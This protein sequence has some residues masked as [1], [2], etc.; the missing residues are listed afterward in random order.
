MG[1]RLFFARVLTVVAAVA[2]WGSAAARAGRGAAVEGPPSS[3]SFSREVKPILAAHCLKCHG[4]TTRKADLDLRG[5]AKMEKGGTTGP[6]IVRGA[7]RKSLLYE[8]IALHTMPPGKAAKLT[9]DQVRLIGRWIDSAHSRTKPTLT[10]PMV[11]PR[12]FTGR[13]GR[14]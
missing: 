5:P 11:I 4:P 2:L 14:R 8:Q 12:S 13:F 3:P 10:S 7:A 6:A 9:D 1:H